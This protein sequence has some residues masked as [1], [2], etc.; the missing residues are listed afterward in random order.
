MI[1]ILPEQPSLARE[2]FDLVP[3]ASKEDD[4]GSHFERLPFGKRDLVL[5]IGVNHAC[6][7]VQFLCVL[8]AQ[9]HYSHSYSLILH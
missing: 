3:Q 6:I 4:R 1:S 7:S 5:L 9:L 8:I 2:N